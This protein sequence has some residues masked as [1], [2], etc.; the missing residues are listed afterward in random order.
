MV[1]ETNEPDPSFRL[2]TDAAAR[3]GQTLGE[4]GEAHRRSPAA[5]CAPLTPLSV[6]SQDSRAQAHGSRFARPTAGHPAAFR[7]EL[8]RGCELRNIGLHHEL[9]LDVHTDRILL[10][11]VGYAAEQAGAG[12]SHQLARGFEPACAHVVADEA[13]GVDDGLEGVDD[14]VKGVDDGVKGVDDGA[15][16]LQRF[17]LCRVE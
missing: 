10:V 7:F 5:A 11:F 14:G 17:W 9:A 15:G 16:Q 6:R 1:P 3:V 12:G 4:G 2:R 13:K 8:H